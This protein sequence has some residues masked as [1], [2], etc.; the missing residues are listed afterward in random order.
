MR[1][2][3]PLASL[4]FFAIVKHYLFL[5]SSNACIGISHF[6]LDYARFKDHT[7]D[8]KKSLYGYGWRFQQ[9][10]NGCLCL[11]FSTKR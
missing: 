1:R 9:K 10:I 7:F 11:A 3:L 2:Q 8:G 6:N 4:H 5:S